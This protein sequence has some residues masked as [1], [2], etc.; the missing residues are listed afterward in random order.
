MSTPSIPPIYEWAQ[1]LS[2]NLE[3]LQ[4]EIQ[5]NKHNKHNNDTQQ[6]II[7]FQTLSDTAEKVRFNGDKIIANVAKKIWGNNVPKTFLT[8]LDIEI[9]IDDDND[10]NNAKNDVDEDHHYSL[11]SN[12][13][14]K[15]MILPALQVTKENI[16]DQL[17]TENIGF[18]DKVNPDIIIPKI[19]ETKQF[20]NDQQ[21]NAF[22]TCVSSKTSID[23]IS[24]AFW[25]FLIDEWKIDHKEI[26]NIIFAR[27]CKQY[28]KLFLSSTSSTSS[29]Q[30]Y[31]DIIFD[32]YYDLMS[33]CIFTSFIKQYPKSNDLFTNDIKLKILHIT[34]KWT[35]GCIPS[36]ISIDH[37]YISKQNN[38]KYNNKKLIE[39]KNNMIPTEIIKKDIIFSHS[40]F[41]QYYLKHE[42]KIECDNKTIFK[43]NMTFAKP[44]TEELSFLESN[45]EVIKCEKETKLAENKFLN[46]QKELAKMIKNDNKSLKHYDTELQQQLFIAKKNKKQFVKDILKQLIPNEL[47]E[48]ETDAY[49]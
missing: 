34:A 23:I 25:W 48:T 15:S 44:L 21:K 9:P 49:L 38:H 45:D 46:S 30:K 16:P 19:I 39:N 33:Q 2:A 27:M 29:T 17:K 26:Q 7:S 42:S 32:N 4:A 36:S 31:K 12:I 5:D 3:K 14:R 8:A 24:D 41:I 40:E 20:E 37:W 18:P 1:S 28:I 47:F 13:K 22:T 11:Q 35:M 10:N 6:T 43:L